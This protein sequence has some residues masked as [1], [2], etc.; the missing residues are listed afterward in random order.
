MSYG[1]LI[2][3][4]FITNTSKFIVSHSTFL[5]FLSYQN[6]KIMSLELTGKIIQIMPETS[7]VSKAG[8]EWKKQE[9]I[10]ETIET[11]PKKVALSMMGD[12]TNDLKRFPVG[13]MITASLNIESREY[14]GKWYTDVRAWRIVASDGS[15]QT[16]NEPSMQQSQTSRTAEPVGDPMSSE[17][18]ATDDLPY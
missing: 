11:Y 6:L 4:T 13:S 7:G 17:Q 15:P 16:S 9:F 2:R 3:S 18:E 12:K 5:L 8:K 14:Q 10:I 1:L